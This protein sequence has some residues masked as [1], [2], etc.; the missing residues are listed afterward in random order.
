MRTSATHQGHGSRIYAFATLADRRQSKIDEITGFISRLTDFPKIGSTRDDLGH[1]LRAIPATE[2]AVVCF[3][4][5][6][7]TLTDFILCVGYA[8]LDWTSRINEQI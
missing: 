7:E 1:G 4:V 3:I 5:N 2:K 6:N 8:G